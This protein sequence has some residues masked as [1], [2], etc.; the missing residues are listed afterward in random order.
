MIPAFE[1][2]EGGY[3]ITE[4]GEIDPV[5]LQIEVSFHLRLKGFCVLETGIEESDLEQAVEAFEVLREQPFRILPT[6]PEV[7]DGILGSKGCGEFS[8]L[9]FLGASDNGDPEG[10]K[11]MQ[12][13]MGQYTDV[14]I[15][16]L[17]EAGFTSVCPVMNLAV[18][19]DEPD[20]HRELT[21]DT[22]MGWLSNFKLSKLMLVLFLGPNEGKLELTP[23]D[24]ESGVVE[25]KTKPGMLVMIRYD[26][27][28][29]NHI[30]TRDDY[31]LVRYI[32][33]RDTTGPRGWRSMALGLQRK[34]PALRALF[35]WA[36]ERMKDTLSLE[37]QYGMTENMTPSRE[38]ELMMNH[39]FFKRNRMPAAVR[40]VASHL[41]GLW[42]PEV[43]WKAVND[44]VD[45]ASKV[46]YTRW[47]HDSYYDP[48]PDCWM[49]AHVYTHSANMGRTS[50][51][52]GAFMD[53][54]T[55]FD[56][57]FFG[58]SP[59]ESNGM[60]PQ[61]RHILETTYECMLMGGFRKKDL[62]NSEIAVYIGT[63][64]PEVNCI[65]MEM[66]ACSG[67]G[68]AVAI[69]SNRISF[70][71]GMTGPSSS[72]ECGMASAHMAI[73]VGITAILP[74]HMHR[75]ATGGLSIAANVG[76]VYFSVTPFNW[77]RF[78]FQMNPMGR[79]LT[80]DESG[81]G[82][83]RGEAVGNLCIVPYAERI[84]GEWAVPDRHCIGTLV[85]MHANSN[86]RCATLT[87]PSGPAQ[88][89]CLAEAIRDAKINPLDLDGLDCHGIGSLLEDSVEVEAARG[90]LRGMPGGEKEVITFGSNKTNSC[91][92]MEA[93]GVVSLFKVFFNIVYANQSPTLHLRVFN[94]HIDMDGDEAVIFNT[95][96]I[97]Y[98][99]RTSF[100]ASQ[101]QGS[102]CG[103]NCVH[104]AWYMADETKV[105]RDPPDMERE[106]FSFWPG[107]GGSLEGN[108][109]PRQGYFI[110]GS[111]T[112]WEEPE[113]MAQDGPGNF[114]YTVTLG[115]NRFESFQI[116]LDGESHRVLHP[117]SSRGLPGDVV[118]GPID[119]SHAWG[120]A[121]IIEGR[122]LVYPY[123]LQN[124]EGRAGDRYQVRLVSSGKYRTV[125]W[126]RLPSTV[127]DSAE[128][129]PVI[130]AGTY[131]VAADWARWSLFEMA[132]SDE[133]PGLYTVKVKLP[134][135]QTE[136][137]FI[138]VRDRDWGQSFFPTE[139][140]A[141]KPESEEQIVGPED[142]EWGN[143][144]RL[145]GRPGESFRID[146]QRTFEEGEDRRKLSWIP[147]G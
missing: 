2:G 105:V 84:D 4:V 75:H 53:G 147:S 51:R 59:M 138:I 134:P 7:L 12:E 79:C 90:V 14:G 114:V 30:S 128:D 88:A 98:R 126:K 136:G 56:N 108:L 140:R 6:P 92:M 42:D 68:S 70:Q 95:E 107:G 122:S 78:N 119:A 10:L 37:D 86:G 74:H 101:S 66:G 96:G 49:Q 43:Y 132:A 141:D 72:V 17:K 137:E 47:D 32:W 117:G 111:W 23:Y 28:R 109:L 91:A 31:A 38:W 60:D 113:E 129:E 9:Q 18:R 65:D 80:F 8:E 52:H 127:S 41:P 25:I 94:P 121:W 73:R 61:Q 89:E 110:V 64:N 20:D 125:T 48:D 82:Y 112:R 106:V 87:A 130:D 24:D 104:I 45:F 58:L 44:G 144:W 71:L 11:L 143:A 124:Q 21:Q 135:G 40:G 85:G 116:W 29:S 55:L 67:T 19:G 5:E 39:H 133:V 46:P 33:A 93:T 35:D 27:L 34:M 115:A 22:C 76:G 26:A 57:K 123:R 62:M 145:G 1:G 69:T 99:E 50:I 118:R 139:P 63:T 16:F 36:G 120:Y 3:D 103:M 13:Y 97:A 15:E 83:V 77:P 102:S 81:G 131:Y 54:I 142:G 146:F 100:H